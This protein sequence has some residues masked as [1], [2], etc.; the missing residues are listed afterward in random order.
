MCFARVVVREMLHILYFVC[1]DLR[2]GGGVRTLT[3][4]DYNIDNIWW[5]SAVIPR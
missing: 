5:C 1:C 4:P 2:G 3:Q